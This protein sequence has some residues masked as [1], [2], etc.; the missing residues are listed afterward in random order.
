MFFKQPLRFTT[1]I[2]SGIQETREEFFRSLLLMINLFC[3]GYFI[4]YLVLGVKFS[5][6]VIGV[7]A[8]IWLPVTFWLNRIGF[9]TFAR[10]SLIIA[11]LTAIS[12]APFGIRETVFAECYFIPAM[13]LGLLVFEANQKLELTFGSMAPLFAWAA[14]RWAP[15]PEFPESWYAQNFPSDFFQVFN[16]IG[17]FIITGYFLYQYGE[18]LNQLRKIALQELEHSRSMERSLEEAQRVAKIGNWEFDLQ[19]GNLVWSK[20]QYRMFELEGVSE[21]ALYEAYR[22]KYHPEDLKLLDQA[23]RDAVERKSN[24]QFE[25]RIICKNGEIRTILAKG[26]SKVDA[27]GVPIKLY[28]TGQD[29]TEQKRTDDLVREQQAKVILNS[30]M[31][32]LGEMAAGIAH[33]I[34][35]PLQVISGKANLLQRACDRGLMDAEQFKTSLQKIESTAN[36]IAKIVKGLRT[37]SRDADADPMQLTSVKQIVEEVFDLSK[38]RLRNNDIEIRLEVEDEIEIEC[39]ATQIEQ[40]ILNLVNNAYDAVLHYTDRWIEVRT[41]KTEDRVQISVTDS[42]RGINAE[43]VDKMMQPFFTTKEIGKGTGL[44]LSI[45]QGIAAN[46][47]GRLFYETKN[48]HTSFVVDLPIQQALAAQRPA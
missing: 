47:S 35:N 32:S 6:F 1:Q 8:F 23:I 29:I 4:L 15:R 3:I 40:V 20:E 19:S 45:S 28:G 27:Q 37:F 26:G 44:G 13:M 46:H 7:V 48:G 12:A 17:A 36:R 38:E 22:E 24:F 31:A 41:K 10:F 21:A 9:Y 25:H 39:R 33:E 5:G 16:F 34:N 42:G 11:S 43:I 14:T 2:E 30:K 18:F